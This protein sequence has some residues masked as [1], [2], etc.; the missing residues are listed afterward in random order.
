MDIVELEGALFSGL[1]AE[2]Y[3]LT[4]VQFINEATNENEDSQKMAKQAL[5]YLR[6]KAAKGDVEAKIK[7]STTLEKQPDEANLWARSIFD[8]KLSSAIGHCAS[9]LISVTEEEGIDGSLLERIIQKTEEEFAED[10]KKGKKAARNLCYLVGILFVESMGVKQDVPR[11]LEYLTKASEMK[12]EVAGLEL[13][14]IL[15]DPFKYPNQYNMEKSL[16]L[17]EGA[18]DQRRNQHNDRALIDLAR[19]YYEGSETVPRDI[20]KSYKYA[21]RVAEKVGEQYCQFIVGDVLLNSQTQPVKGDVRKAVF[22]L[23]QSAE[24]GFPLAIETLSKI[25]FEGKVRGIKQDYEKAYFWCL[26]GDDLWPSGL[27]YCQTCLGD[28]YR[29][30]LGV[31]K[32]II[33]S[34]EYY[35]KA[36]TQQD[37]PQNYARYM[38]GEMF[39]GASGWKRDLDLAEEYYKMAA[40]E[41][42]QPACDRL[43]E[44]RSLREEKQKER[45]AEKRNTWRIWSFFG[46]RK[47]QIA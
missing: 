8:R 31:P 28:I 27:G 41:H 25:F 19:V 12:H 42:Y 6:I 44:I 34:F 35:Q 13:A 5:R 23:T 1:P 40:N 20:E 16:A 10:D 38:L 32:D 24:Q 15:S 36:A 37:A 21:H 33:R 47:K 39:F 14:K 18:I 22:W 29:E 46:S 11:G 9:Y 3:L 43:E 4:A 7:L 2:L 17:Y 45:Y 26:K 30:G